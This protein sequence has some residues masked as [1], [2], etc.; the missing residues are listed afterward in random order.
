MSI[1]ADL[2]LLLTDDDTGKSAASATL[3]DIA[4]GGALLVEL[5]LSQ[6]ADVTGGDGQA[7]RGRPVVRDL[8]KTRCSTAR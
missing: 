5:T 4:L 2:L 1:A 8:R 3:V 7:P 6:R